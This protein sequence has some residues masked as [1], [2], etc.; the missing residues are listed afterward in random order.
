[1]SAGLE[2]QR[3]SL[4]TK[5]AVGKGGSI[6]GSAISIVGALLALFGF[7][8]P[9][10][11]CSGYNFSGLELVTES[12]AGNTDD[13]VI[14]LLCLVPFFSLGALGVAI[15]VIPV[16]LWKKAG[17]GLR[18]IGSALICL[19]AALACCP[20]FLFYVRVQADRQDPSNFG[21]TFLQIEEG[22]WFSVFGLFVTLFGGMFGFGASIAGKM[23]IKKE[24]SP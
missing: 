24:P 13:P 20:S 1:M 9:W 18:L 5:T 14:S 8:L 7:V 19:L 2:S 16:S 15:L 17:H 11:S 22:F 23:M 12:L 3:S 4:D 10:V 21:V 6:A